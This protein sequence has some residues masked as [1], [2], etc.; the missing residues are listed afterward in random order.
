MA[1]IC[2]ENLVQRKRKQELERTAAIKTSCM[3]YSS[4][5][6][7]DE[8]LDYTKNLAKITSRTLKRIEEDEV[9]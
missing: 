4:E 1:P 5:F 2:Q 9:V 6:T 8:I 7:K 3:L